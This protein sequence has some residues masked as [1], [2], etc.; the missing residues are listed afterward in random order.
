MVRVNTIRGVY[1]AIVGPLTYGL[2]SGLLG[3]L[4]AIKF[5]ESRL[6]I[7]VRSIV[8]LVDYNYY[9]I[10]KDSNVVGKDKQSYLL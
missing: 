3:L 6:N 2:S 8:L 9:Q 7:F 10:F 4:A 5:D 1:P